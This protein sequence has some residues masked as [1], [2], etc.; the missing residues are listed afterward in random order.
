MENV[1]EQILSYPHLSVDEQREVEAYV[2][3]NPKWAPLLRD[4]RALEGLAEGM[5]G[6]LPSDAFL[7]TYVVARHLHPDEVPPDLEEVFSRLEAR[8]A[9]D[10]ALRQQVEAARQRLEEAEAAIDPVAQF[11]TLTGRALDAEGKTV[12]ADTSETT[13]RRASAPSILDVLLN[14][15]VLLRRGAV[16]VVLLVGLYGVL[17]ATSI[18]TQSTVDR[19]AAVEVSDQLLDSYTPDDTRGGISKTDTLSVDERY[20]E[21]LTVLRTARTSTLGLFPRYDAEKLD[22]AERLLTQVVEDVEPQSFLALEARFYLGKVALA[23]EDVSTARRHLQMVVEHGG[24]QAGK[25][26]KILTTLQRESL[27]SGPS[28]ESE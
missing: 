23:Q 9:E 6:A 16:A 19:L 20:L 11:E 3:S 24:R 7:A 13:G 22:R 5:R 2:E 18:A 10:D 27:T 15:P 17:Y 25:A 12:E 1:E 28:S 4:V 26:Q 21:A 14:L 8:I